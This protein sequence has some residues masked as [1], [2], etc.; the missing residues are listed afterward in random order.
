VLT[1]QEAQGGCVVGTVGRET[2]L[3]LF[4]SHALKPWKKKWWVLQLDQEYLQRMEAVLEEPNRS[5]DKR[6]SPR[7]KDSRSFD[8][9]LSMPNHPSRGS[10]QDLAASWFCAG[11]RNPSGRSR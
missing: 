10:I 9:R 1:A 7:F 11:H 8:E 5:L 4:V 3:G 6:N 2:I